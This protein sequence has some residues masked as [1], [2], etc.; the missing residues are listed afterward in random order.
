MTGFDLI[1][2]GTQ[3]NYYFHENIFSKHKLY[4]WVSQIDIITSFTNWLI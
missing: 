1:F 2:P 3:N 4:L